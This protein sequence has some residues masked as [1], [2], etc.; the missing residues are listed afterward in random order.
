MF[1]GNQEN[2]LRKITASIVIPVYNEEK[3]IDKCILSIL[4]QN[5]DKNKLEVLF[6]DGRSNDK[7]KDIILSYCKK[8]SFIRVL[9][10]PKRK[11][12]FGSNIGIRA[13]NGQYIIRMDAHSEYADNYVSQNIEY[14][15]KTGADNVG[16]PM[17]AKGKTPLQKVIAAA[18]P[19]KFA[20]GGGKFHDENYEGYADTVYLGAFKRETL[21]DLGLYDENLQCTDDDDLNFRITQNGGKIYISPKIKSTYYPRNSRKDLFKQYFNYGLWKVAVIKKH[22][23][24][25]RISHL[26]PVIF[27]LFLSIG[28]V[29]SVFSKLFCCLFM[30]ILFLYFIL[31]VYFSFSNKHVHTF[32]DKLR[33][34]FIHFILHISYGIGFLAGIFKFFGYK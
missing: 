15:E 18:Y 19:S 31:N 12:Q 29:F 22:K 14:L 34:M 16:G 25:A 8:F 33:L 27:V 10:N 17:I 3:Y 30:S 21:F 5:F 6:I 28:L 24:P 1:K 26:V 20:F 13:S 2:T 7:T 9:D 4:N 11:I 23:R 32:A